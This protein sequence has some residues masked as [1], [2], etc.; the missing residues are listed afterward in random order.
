VQCAY[1]NGELIECKKTLESINYQGTCGAEV[2]SSS[3]DV[4][5][6][7]MDNGKI[8]G[9]GN[10]PNDIFSDFELNVVLSGKK[11]IV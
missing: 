8:G 7:I 11:A 9:G 6:N 3:S 1:V 2:P 4:Y 5:D 10:T